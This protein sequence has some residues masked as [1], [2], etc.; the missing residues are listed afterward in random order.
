MSKAFLDT[1]DPA[2]AIRQL[3]RILATLKIT[4]N[5]VGFPWKGK[6]EGNTEIGI[7]NP[8]EYIPQNFLLTYAKG[9]N[10]IV[11]GTENWDLNK[12]TLKNTSGTDAEIEV[13]FY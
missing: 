7:L 8:L 9:S 1:R 5:F 11:A 13:F 2:Q 6:I 4:D 3:N 10:T 12:V